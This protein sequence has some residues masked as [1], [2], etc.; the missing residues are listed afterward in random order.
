MI[1]FSSI[2]FFCKQQNFVLLKVEEKEYLTREEKKC[3]SPTFD[4][5][6]KIKRV[7]CLS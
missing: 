3:S 1:I 2:C 6:K 7:F 4:S 5:K